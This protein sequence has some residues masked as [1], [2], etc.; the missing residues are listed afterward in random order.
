MITYFGGTLEANDESNSIFLEFLK[1][2]S[3]NFDVLKTDPTQLKQL[4]D[5]S[6]EQDA[7]WGLAIIVEISDENI[8]KAEEQFNK[9]L[10]KITC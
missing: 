7:Y 8:Q 2:Q 5:L 4:L 6:V 3:V 1:K 9:I 10:D